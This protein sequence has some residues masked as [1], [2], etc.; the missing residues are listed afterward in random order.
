MAVPNPISDPATTYAQLLQIDF[1]NSGEKAVATYQDVSAYDQAFL[2]EEKN[3]LV[4]QFKTEEG[5]KDTAVDLASGARQVLPEPQ[6]PLVFQSWDRIAWGWDPVRS[7]AVALLKDSS[8][9]INGASNHTVISW[10]PFDG[11]V[12]AATPLFMFPAKGTFSGN[13]RLIASVYDPKAYEF[14]VA[15]DDE[16]EVSGILVV[17][18]VTGNFKALARFG[19]HS[20]PRQMVVLY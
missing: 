7:R 14:L 20:A 1:A 5:W 11:T 15:Y 6:Y 2:I 3:L 9:T 4:A 8:F 16:T 12:S 17:D 19:I 13:P 10:N 18:A